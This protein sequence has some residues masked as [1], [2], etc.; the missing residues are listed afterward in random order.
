M[1]EI[2]STFKQ[3]KPEDIRSSLKKMW[4]ED[5]YDFCNKNLN[6]TSQEMMDSLIKFEAD[7]KTI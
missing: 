6:E 5:F 4:L 3:L 1:Q 7:F 2:Q